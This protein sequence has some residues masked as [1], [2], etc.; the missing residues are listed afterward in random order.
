MK[1][2]I[3]I[4]KALSDPNRVLI[5]KML[6]QGKLC[7]C[8]ITAVL[9]LA[10]STVSKHLKIL[11]DAELVEASKEG[12]WVNYEL[13]KNSPGPYAAIMREQLK[14]WLADDRQVQEMIAKVAMADRQKICAA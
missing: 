13:A 14:T 4:M 3:R 2:F 10:Q 7:V 9:G 6:E 11:E 8:E 5:M 1:S 12:S